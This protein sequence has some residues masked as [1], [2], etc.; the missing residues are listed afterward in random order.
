MGTF[1][2]PEEV[3]KA[4]NVGLLQYIEQTDPSR[5]HPKGRDFTL[6]GHNS[7]I[8]SRNGRW[9]Y[10]SKGIG[11]RNAL[12]FLMK[13]EGKSFQDAVYAIL[14][15]S[16][17]SYQRPGYEERKQEEKKLV[18][19]E[20]DSNTRI[21]EEYLQSR[22]ITPDVIQFF[23]WKGDIYQSVSYH[24][25]CFVGRDLEGNPR[26]VSVRGTVGSFKQNA[27]GSDRRYCFQNGYPGRKTAHLFEAPIDMLSYAVLMSE[28]GYDFRTFNLIALSGITG[29]GDAERAKLP[30]AMEQYIRE[31]PEVHTFYTHFD[32]DEAGVTAGIL[33]A[34]AVPEGKQVVIQ[35][36]PHGY[37]DVNEYLQKRP[38]APAVNA[39]QRTMT[40]TQGEALRRL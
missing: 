33:L 38:F 2:P 24:S 12:D 19:P 27:A 8:L 16:P 6:D 9:N 7:F 15:T 17:E 34:R 39:D 13:M 10:A 18:L 35:S 3:E 20:R 11:G 25:A 32:N 29:K 26:M 23:I 21:V 37:K 30:I 14:N 5:L 4:K 28:R 40:E 36:P 22:G 31:H 1:I